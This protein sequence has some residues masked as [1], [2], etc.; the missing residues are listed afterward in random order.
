MVLEPTRVSSIL[1]LV[2]TNKVN[3]VCDVRV[4]DN[5]PGTN[6]DAVIF[7]TN[8]HKPRP[9][10]QKQWTYNFKWADFSRY[11]EL[12]SKVPWDCCFLRDSINDCWIKFR[13]VL[14]SVA[15]QCIPKT[16][17]CPKKRMHWLSGQTLR[18]VLKKRRAYKLAKWSGKPH[19]FQR[20][21]VI[22]NEVR[23]LTRQDH[24]HH[25]N[26]ITSNL[27][28]DQRLFWRWLK[29]VRGQHSRFPDLHH[30]GNTLSYPSEK[31]RAFRDHF[32]SIFVQ[33]NASHLSTLREELRDSWSYTKK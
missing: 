16:T 15:D 28:N 5:L 29:N 2:F 30:Q 1:D 24:H 22:S 31:A 4:V 23:S 3:G 10:G 26:Q 21:R 20:Y 13:N 25:L 6:H 19:H 33:E 9:L 12:L 17:L 8:F 18:M 7:T 32:E 27:H 14:L 11:R